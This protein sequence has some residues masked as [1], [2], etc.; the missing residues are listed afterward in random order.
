[1]DPFVTA[2]VEEVQSPEMRPANLINAIITHKTVN[3][4]NIPL[5]PLSLLFD[6]VALRPSM[7]AVKIKPKIL[8]QTRNVSL[9]HVHRK[10]HTWDHISE[11]VMKIL[12]NAKL[13][14]TGSYE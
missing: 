4:T 10:R 1:M 14:V 7:Y 6:N 13:S 3:F 5:F 2:T 9:I 12:S 8:L 11:I